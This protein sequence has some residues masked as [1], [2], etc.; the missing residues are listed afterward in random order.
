MKKLFQSQQVS[1]D[2]FIVWITDRVKQL[3]KDIDADVFAS[4]I[5]GVDSPNDVS[6]SFLLNRN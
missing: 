1:N 4:F 6:C 5:E 2:P 3:N